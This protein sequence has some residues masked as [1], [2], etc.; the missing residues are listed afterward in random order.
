MVV[1]LGVPNRRDVGTEPSGMNAAM[2][3]VLG[4]RAYSGESEP[5]TGC[6]RG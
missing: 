6:F 5:A 2:S 4:M 3:V 1:V